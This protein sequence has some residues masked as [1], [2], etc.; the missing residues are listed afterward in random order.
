M[1]DNYVSHTGRTY[2]FRANIGQ[3]RNWGTGID[4]FKFFSCED[5]GALLMEKD[6][7]IHDAWHT[8]TK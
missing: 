3:E 2:H 5:C 8:K 6:I 4:Y 1:E 7:D